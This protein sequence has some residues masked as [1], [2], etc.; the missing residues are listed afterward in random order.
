MAGAIPITLR[1]AEGAMVRS[2]D[3]R[4]LA[5]FLAELDEHGWSAARELL[6]RLADQQ[7]HETSGDTQ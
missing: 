5:R 2:L 4:R 3:D 6:P 7:Q 1:P